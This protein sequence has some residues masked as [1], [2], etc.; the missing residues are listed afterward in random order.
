MNKNLLEKIDGLI[1]E[2]QRSQEYIDFIEKKTAIQGNELSQSLINE[3]HS[4]MVVLQAERIQ[5]KS[6]PETEERMREICNTASFDDDLLMYLTAEFSIHSL[7]SEIYKR[8]AN[9]VEID[10]DILES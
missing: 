5:G 6:N 9:S 4:L 2:I 8:I 7:L 3:Y 1:C 10:L